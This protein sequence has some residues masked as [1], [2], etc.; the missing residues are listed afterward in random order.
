MVAKE[1]GVIGGVA[2]VAASIWGFLLF[3]IFSGPDELDTMEGAGSEDDGV[4][5]MFEEALDAE[6]GMSPADQEEASA[7]D[8]PGEEDT[9]R[10]P[11]EDSTGINEDL[12]EEEQGMSG[13]EGHLIR[14][15]GIR[16]G[17]FPDIAS[18]DAV[19]ERIEEEE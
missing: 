13:T 11:E 15:R 3:T 18:V 14:E 19:L 10:M 1:K 12:V 16:P 8:D 6:N 17:D 5:E 7:L 9:P 2:I 4:P